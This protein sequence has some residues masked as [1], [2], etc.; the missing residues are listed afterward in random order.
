VTRRWLAVAHH[1]PNRTRLRSHLLVRD[2]H[3]CEGLA[4]ELST[5]DGVP[6]VR[7]RPYTGSALIRHDERLA[8]TTL[9]DAAS[10]RLGCDRV[11]PIGAPLPVLDDTIPEF[12]LLASHIVALVRDIDGR[13]RLRSQ[14]SFA[15]GTLAT[16]GFFG[17]GAT[18][19][20]AAGRLDL[21]PWF[22][23]AWWGYRMFM[24]TH[25]TELGADADATPTGATA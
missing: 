22:N 16:L 13:I 20:V 7:V 19:V 11:L 5:L 14:G 2:A 6:E 24:T 1:L 3:A 25:P 4:E 8:L 10:R 15:L 17:A 9:T 23:L 18:Q 21:P 12:S